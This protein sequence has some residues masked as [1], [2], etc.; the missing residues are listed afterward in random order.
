MKIIRATQFITRHKTRAP[1]NIHSSSVLLRTSS[2]SS[3]G[4]SICTN[5][6]RKQ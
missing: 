6:Q 1:F 4:V 3:I 2:V 5:T